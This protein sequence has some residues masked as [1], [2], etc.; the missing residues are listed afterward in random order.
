METRGPQ[1]RGSHIHIVYITN[2][3]E[4]NGTEQ[5]RHITSWNGAGVYNIAENE[6]ELLVDRQAE[7]IA[8]MTPVSAK[9]AKKKKKVKSFNICTSVRVL[10]TFP[11]A[12]ILRFSSGE[13]TCTI[14]Y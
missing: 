9:A 2:W 7:T 11:K 5:L 14:M 8:E 6:L 4:Q 10:C 12:P 3:P 13:R 1:N